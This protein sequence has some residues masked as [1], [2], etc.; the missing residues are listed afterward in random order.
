M[1]IFDPIWDACSVCGGDFQ[2]TRKGT[3]RQHGPNNRRCAGSGK[4]PASSARPPVETVHL[5]TEATP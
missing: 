2:V 4:T 3:I 1:K 5:P